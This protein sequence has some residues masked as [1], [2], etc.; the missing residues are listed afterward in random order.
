VTTPAEALRELLGSGRVLVPR[1]YKPGRATGRAAVNHFALYAARKGLG[2]DPEDAPTRPLT[3]WRGLELAV[4]G[5]EGKADYRAVPGDAEIP[6]EELRARIP[7]YPAKPHFVVDFRFWNE[8]SR[9]GQTNL[10]RQTS[11]TASTLRRYLS[12]RHLTIVNAPSEARRRF[13]KA[14]PTFEGGF[15]DWEELLSELGEDRVVLLDPNADEEL[16]ERDLERYDVFVLGGI[17]DNNMQGWTEKLAPGIPADVV[18][19]KITLRGRVE[20][21]PDR[22]NSLVEALCRVIVEGESLR[23]AV[24]SVQ[25]PRFARR[26]LRIELR[27]VDRL[28]RETLEE[29]REVVNLPREEIIARAREMGIPVEVDLQDG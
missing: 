4:P 2:F 12:D 7:D 16:T 24:L 8:H 21:V 13:G 22:I 11:V 28:D 6:A 18:R 19:R 14:F 15:R 3:S 26:R 1:G 9:F 25:S 20:G 29:I 10:I 27:R 5:N 23:E 17:V